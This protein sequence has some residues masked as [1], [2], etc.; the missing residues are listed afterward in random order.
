MADALKGI[1]GGSSMKQFI[2]HHGLAIILG[3]GIAACLFFGYSLEHKA[4]TPASPPG[5]AFA[6]VFV[7]DPAA[8]LDLTATINP[9]SPWSDQLTV[10]VKGV[11]A[12]RDRWLLVIECPPGSAS[13]PSP[14]TLSF[15]PATQTSVPSSAVGVY[16]G[17]GRSRT[18]E[19]GCFTRTKSNSLNRSNTPGYASI[20]SVTLPTLET[21]QAIE[22]AISSPTLY[23][24][25][26]TSAGPVHLIEVF[27]GA[28]CP[29]PSPAVT[30]AATTPS[31][32]P[33]V[34]ASSSPG[35]QPVSSSAASPSAS[36]SQ[37]I[38]E[39]FGQ[40]SASA[41]SGEYYLPSSTETKE[42]L[43]NVNLTGYQVESIFP[44]PSQIAPAKSS[45]G[46]SAA[47]D[48]TWSGPSS[49]S[50]SMIVSNLAGQ[51]QVSRY[52]FLAGILLGIA[53]GA[54]VTFLERIWPKHIFP[55]NKRK[56]APAVTMG[57]AAAA[58]SEPGPTSR[59]GGP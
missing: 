38:P 56:K 43:T 11:P 12:K 30:Q 17:A 32:S 57:K 36:P 39:C 4:F 3:A 7:Q 41:T 31:A 20:G 37:G 35:I 9:D 27:A 10:E 6:V 2:D 34:S 23:D 21:D 55:K 48:Y 42:T 8:T 59:D 58:G 22:N 15:E 46:Q 26:K 50:P 16:P 49:L 45:P 53:G 25:Q 29:S 14:G 1:R 5:Q 54:V 40:G 13:P 18:F 51:Q 52:T 44:N 19:L 24:A 28:D 47:E 33:S